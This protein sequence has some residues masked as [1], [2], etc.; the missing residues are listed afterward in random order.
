[1]DNWEGA[2]DEGEIQ[3][4]GPNIT[5]G[6]YGLEKETKELFTKDGWMMTGD[7]GKFDEEGFLFITDRKKELFKTAY[8]KY[9]APQVLEGMLKNQPH[10][11]MAVIV[12][13]DRKYVGALIAP[14]FERLEPWAKKNGVSFSS[15]EELIE[16]EKVK[17]LIESEV[18][19]VNG[20]LARFEQVKRFELLPRELTQEEDELTP[21]LKVKRRVINEVYAAKIEALYPSK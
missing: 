10:I 8:G 13:E 12:G 3:C 14:D 17:A 9:I 4:R 11:A 15:R 20:D 6:Y 7:V 18:I 1:M 16:N 2:E 19:A 5:Q 21:T